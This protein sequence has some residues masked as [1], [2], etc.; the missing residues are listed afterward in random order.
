M[1]IKKCIYINNVDVEGKK[2]PNKPIC[3]K[4]TLEDDS[5]LEIPLDPANTD[6]AEIMR[7]VNAGELTIDEEE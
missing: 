4:T 2:I 1:K 3:V 5:I 7:Q 6:Y